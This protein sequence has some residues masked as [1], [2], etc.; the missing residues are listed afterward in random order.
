MTFLYRDLE[1]KFQ[2]LY[3]SDSPV[4][5]RMENVTYPTNSGGESLAATSHGHSSAIIACE[6]RITQR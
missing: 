3:D 1:F 2:A 6:Q 4:I 5:Q